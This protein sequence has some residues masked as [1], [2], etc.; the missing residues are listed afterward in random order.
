MRIIDISKSFFGTEPYPGDPAVGAEPWYDLA[1]GDICCVHA[2]RMGTH[3]S[4]HLD[5]PCHFLEGGGGVDEIDLER[6]VGP[7]QVVEAGEGRLDAATLARLLPIGTRRLLIKG[8]AILTPEGAEF[9]VREGLWLFGTERDTVGDSVTGP[10]VHRILLGA[11]IVIV[12]NLRLEEAAEG[13]YTLCAQP[14]KL[15][16]MDGSPVRAILLTD[17]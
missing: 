9:L 12:E 14:L 1:K 13:E 3:A 11:K 17:R 7:C 4:T 5:A 2:L 15:E 6:C 10:T 8:P 16:G